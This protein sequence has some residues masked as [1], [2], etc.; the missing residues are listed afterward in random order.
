MRQYYIDNIRYFIIIIVVV[1]H[2]IFIYNGQPIIGKIGS[3]YK[4][5]IQDIFQYIVYPWIMVLLYNISGISTYHYLLKYNNFIA[6][7]TVKL[8]VPSTLGILLYGWILG[9]YNLVIGGSIKLLPKDF[10]NFFFYLLC[11]FSGIGPLWFNQILWINSLLLVLIRR[12]EKNRILNFFSNVNFLTVLS[13]GFGLWIS[14]QVLNTPVVIT[15]RFGIY[16]YSYLIGYYVFSQENNIKYLVSNSFI[17][18]IIDVILGFF[19]T[20]KYFGED[21]TANQVFTGPLSICY[22]WVS[23]LTIFG[24]GKKYF[25]KE[26]AFTR[27]MRKKSYGIYVFH[28]LFITLAAYYLNI[29]SSLN[30]LY[31]YIL[32]GLSGIFGSMII[33]EIVFKIPYINWIVLGISQKKINKK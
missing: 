5:Q 28:Y 33:Y 22:S 2:V 4:N 6:D 27:F 10:N 31:K 15:Y 23:C 16:A 29:Y 20:Y 19:F 7:R 30:L 26:Y 24:I 11:C 25:N 1:F 8:L 9:Y 32:V 12:Y 14:A 3:P 21:F 13:L 18:L 17:L